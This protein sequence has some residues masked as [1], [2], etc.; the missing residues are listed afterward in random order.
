MLSPQTFDHVRAK[1]GL[2]RVVVWAG[3]LALGGVA[4]V[5]PVEVSAAAGS[6]LA[7]LL[8]ARRVSPAVVAAAFAVAALGA[9]RAG[10]SISRHE[11]R[12]ERADVALPSP[13]RCSAR[14]RV[15]SSPV[16]VRGTLRFDAQLHDL[17][18]DGD[19]V[20]WS[21]R[22]TL[23]G[24][25]PE[26]AREDEVEVVA[27]LAPPQR[28]WNASG[29]DPHPGEARRGTVRSGGAIDVRVLRRGRGLAAR[30]DRLR[31]RIR[32]RIDAT[33]P[34][35]LAP[36]ARALVLGESDLAPDDDA[37][38]RTSGLSHLLAVS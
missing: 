7:L 19:A 17:V 2:D 11:R 4:P 22:A 30:I 34:S 32:A 37:S 23:Y 20:D 9:V 18:C 33:F 28:L 1:P 36:M 26:L 21:G 5:A 38:F 27:A 13:A 6:I 29:G 24:G 8:L 10:A 15:E 16:S 31:A 14:A 12:A 3:A 25:P 35:D